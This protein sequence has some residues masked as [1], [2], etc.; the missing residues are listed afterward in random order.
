MGGPPKV[1]AAIAVVWPVTV[2]VYCSI[3]VIKA[4]T[5]TCL[6]VPHA[7]LERGI[8]GIHRVKGFGFDRGM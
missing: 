8:Q 7:N 4:S 2:R 1:L 3:R 6:G 5:S